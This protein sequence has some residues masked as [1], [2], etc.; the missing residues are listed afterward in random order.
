MIHSIDKDKRIKLRDFLL[1][2]TVCYELCVIRC[3]GWVVATAW[4]D[5]EDLFK[6]P[7]EYLDHIVVDDAWGTLVAVK[8]DG[9]KQYINCHYIDI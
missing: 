4:I 3:D 9:V 2:G 7:T 6:V 5:D 8:E 1:Y